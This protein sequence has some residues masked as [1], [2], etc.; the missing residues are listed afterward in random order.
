MKHTRGIRGEGRVGCVIWLAIVGLIAYS[1]FK[2]V[3]VKIANSSF[4]DYMTEEA[5]F[6]SI[7]SAKQIE[8]EIIAKAKDLEIPVTADNLKVT[9]TREKITIEAHYTL[10]IV[11]FGGAYT[12]VWKCDPVVE[13]PM[14]VV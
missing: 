13:R 3:P 14:F 7:K 5:S 8:T 11:F 2:I 12:Y 4:E 9:R 6:G 1:L 10:N